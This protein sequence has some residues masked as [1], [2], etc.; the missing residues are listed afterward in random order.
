MNEMENNI[1]QP[2]PE[3]NIPETTE[4]PEEIISDVTEPETHAAVEAIPYKANKKLPKK[5]LIYV[6]AAVAAVAVVAAIV[7]AA[8]ASSPLA[9]V[10]KGA[11]NSAEALVNN[12]VVALLSDVADGGSVELACDLETITESILGYGMDGSA[13]VKLY[14]NSDPQIALVAD[15][16]VDDED[17]IDLTITASEKEIAASSELLFGDDAYGI[18]LKTA[19]KKFDNSVFGPDGEYSLGVESLEDIMDTAE[20]SDEIVKDA[21]KVA[22]EFIDAM[23]KSLRKHAEIEKSRDI[24]DFNGTDTKTSAVEIT[25][26]STSLAGMYSDL[27]DFA[28]KNKTF[29]NFL[30]DNA[31]TVINGMYAADMLYFTYD[32]PTEP[33]DNF[34]E[35]L[36]EMVADM[37]TTMARIERA[38]VDIS[39]TCHVSKSGKY[40]VGVEVDGQFYEEKVRASIIAGPSLDKLEEISI[41][42]TDNATTARVTYT[43]DT[44]TKN[45]YVSELKIREDGEVLISGDFTW[46]KKDGDFELTFTD[47]WGDTYGAE[48]SIDKHGKSTTITL[49]SVNGEGETFDLD[50]DLILTTSD[51]MPSVSHYVD[52]MDM[53]EDDMEDLIYDIEQISWNLPFYF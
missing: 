23:I 26:T 43:V 47:E 38:D 20:N 30:Y 32:D 8:V 39:L 27:I 41:H 22:D 53:D 40:L 24:L 2:I 25:L 21:E 46:D 42:Y 13:S 52:L 35:E 44:N 16:E 9:L 5:P 49:N 15:V 31:E 37:E 34:Y 17:L 19:A 6:A 51:K 18:N 45:E 3:E 28:Y 48:G 7:S 29:K 50:V 12:E 4:T 11:K 33:I 10:A 14:T 1:N 36:E